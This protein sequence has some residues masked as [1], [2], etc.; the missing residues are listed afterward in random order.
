MSLEEYRYSVQDP[1]YDGYRATED[2]E[3]SKKSLGCIDLNVSAMTESEIAGVCV[4]NDRVCQQ[5]LEVVEADKERR[6]GA[7]A[8]IGNSAY[9]VD[10]ESMSD[11]L[12][13]DSLSAIDRFWLTYARE[14]L[15]GQ[16]LTLW[17]VPSMDTEKREYCDWRDNHRWCGSWRA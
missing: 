11:R 13:S 14:R 3:A 5:L 6:C 12:P 16:N 4:V 8:A 9:F 1:A 7:L 10:D 15:L 17:E 2:K